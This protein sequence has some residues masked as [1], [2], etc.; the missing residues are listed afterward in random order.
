[1]QRR[2]I[3]SL[4]DDDNNNNTN[5]SEKRNF[6]FY[7]STLNR[8]K[9]FPSFTKSKRSLIIAKCLLTKLLLYLST[10]LFLML[11]LVNRLEWMW[12]SKWV[13]G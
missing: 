1:M 2:K 11:I 5:S 3:I 7:T 4:N 8:R 6:F 12:F 10:F 13:G 9:K